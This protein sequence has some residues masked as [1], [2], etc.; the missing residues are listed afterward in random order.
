MNSGYTYRSRIDA[1][2]DGQPLASYL[3][4]RYPHSSLDTWLARLAGGEIELAGRR[5]SPGEVGRQGDLLAWHRPPWAEPDVPRHFA[6]LYEDADVLAVA[7]PGGLPTMPAGGYLEHTLVHL[8]RRNWPSA[9]A[10]HRLGRATS[11]VVLFALTSAAAAALARALRDR[12]VEKTYRALVAGAPAWDLLEA[13]TPI[14]LVPHPRLGRVYAAHAGGRE[15]RS[16]L[17]VVERRDGT[18]LLAVTIATGRPHQIRIHAAA[19]GHPLAG[20]P[21]YAPGG[22]PSAAALP[23]DGGYH[24]HAWRVGFAHPRTA[25]HREV[26]APLPEPLRLATER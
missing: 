12:R 2:G 19:A 13:T 9:H 1:G 25:R 26:V 3:A 21:L 5:A 18:T 15:A 4:A 16:R 20:D 8:V 24:L 7:K 14:G 23:G 10:V 17:A 6:V 11:G 22:L